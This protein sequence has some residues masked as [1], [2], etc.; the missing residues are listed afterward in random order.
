MDSTSGG[1]SHESAGSQG[2][3]ADTANTAS[4]RKQTPLWAWGILAIAVCAMSS[5]GIWF[6]LMG[7]APS[8]LKACWRL[9][10]TAAVQFP[11]AAM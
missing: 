6:R 5:G 8:W 3:A 11:K 9:T 1:E 7:D 10:L 2:T 4:E